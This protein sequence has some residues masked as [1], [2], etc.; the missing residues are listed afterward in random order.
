MHHWIAPFPIDSLSH[1]LYAPHRQCNVTTFFKIHVRMVPM[2]NKKQTNQ[3]EMQPKDAAD[4]L[5]MQVL[6]AEGL[7]VDDKYLT[8]MKIISTGLGEDVD[9][10]IVPGDGWRYHPQTNEIEFPVDMLLTASPEEII[11]FSAHEAG[12]RQVTRLNMR[13]G[14]FRN[15]YA[16]ESTRM[17]LNAVEDIRVDNWLTGV[18]PGLK[19]YL[20][21]AYE[22]LLPA[23]LAK[24]QYVERL[25]H[26]LAIQPDFSLHPY[27]LYPHLEYLLGARY[28]WKFGSL[29]PRT[30]SPEVMEALEK[31]RNDLDVIFRLYPPGKASEREKLQFAEETA[32]MITDKI[33]P[34][35]MYLVETAILRMLDAIQ[36]GK[37]EPKGRKCIPGESSAKE[38]K[39]EAKRVIEY[40]AKEV[41][42]KLSAKTQKRASRRAETYREGRA[43]EKETPTEE[44]KGE[45]EKAEEKK[46][47]L[48]PTETLRD[49]IKKERMISRDQA[50]QTGE[51]ER[52]YLLISNVIQMLSGIL[53]NHFAKNRRPGFTGYFRSGQKPDLR[54][55]M[56]LSRKLT[57]GI[58]VQEKDLKVFLKRKLPSQRDHKIV[59]ALDESG[60]MTEPKRTSALAGVLVFMEALD[61][62]G[63]DFAV[64]GFADSTVVHK[65]LG[66]KLTSGDK[67]DLFEEVAMCIP[68]GSTA[69][70][71]AL[72][73]AT[74]ILKDQPQDALRWIIMVTDGEG[75]INTT[76]K[77]FAQLQDEA[78]AQKIE[79]LG[80]GLDKEVTE[81]KKRYQTA[82]QVENVEELPDILSKILEERLVHQEIYWENVL[83]DNGAGKIAAPI[84]AQPLPENVSEL[85]AA[86]YLHQKERIP[87]FNIRHLKR[88]SELLGFLLKRGCPEKESLFRS[89]RYAFTDTQ[90]N[91]QKVRELL[92]EK[93]SDIESIFPDF[94]HYDMY[95]VSTAKDGTVTAIPRD[96]GTLLD[97][98]MKG[99]SEPQLQKALSILRE[100][101]SSS[102]KAFACIP[103]LEAAYR[104]LS[105]D[106]IGDVILEEL[107]NKLADPSWS[108]RQTAAL[109]LGRI[110]LYLIKQGKEADPAILEERLKDEDPSVC[111]AAADSLSRIWY[112]SYRQG[113]LSTETLEEKMDDE[114]WSVRQAASRT[115]GLIY[116][117]LIKEGKEINVS[118]MED[119]LWDRNWFVRQAEAETM[120]IVYP[121]IIKG[122]IQIDPNNLEERLKDKNILVR[123]TAALSLGRIYPAM[124]KGGNDVDLNKLEERLEDDDWSVRQATAQALGRIWFH[125][126][127]QGKVPLNLL[128]KKLAHGNWSVRQAASQ[129][130]G[131]IYPLLIKGGSNIKL[132]KLEERLHDEDVD[133]S[134]C[135][136]AAIALGKIWPSSY[137][138]KKIT[139]GALEEKLKDD[140][141]FVHQAAALAIINLYPALVSED[142]GIDISKLQR[143][144]KDKDWSIRQA[145]AQVSI[146]ITSSFI[147]NNQD[148]LNDL[149]AAFHQKLGEPMK[150]TISGTHAD[151]V[152]MTDETLTIGDI[153]LEREAINEDIPE[154]I[155]TATGYHILESLIFGYLLKHS[156]LLLGPTS[157][158][159]SFL[160]KWLAHVLGFKHLAYAIN[161]F[162]SKFEL[163]GGIK[164]DNEGHFIWHEGIILKAAHEG[165]WLVLE[166]INLASSEVVEILNDFLITGKI[167]YSENGQQR[168]VTPHP[169]FRLFATGNPESYS[170]RQKLSE[171]FISR[172]KIFYQK[173]LSEEE[174]SQVLSSLFR[175]SASMAL[176]IARFHI[177]LQNQADSRVIGKAEK[178]PY[179]FTLRDIIRIGNRLGTTLKQDA[180]NEGFLKK[181]FIEFFCVYMGRVRDE[182]EREAMVSL[183]D[184]Y[185]GFRA[186]G[187]DLEAIIPAVSKDI[188]PL[189][190]SLKTTRG[191]EFIPQQEADITPTPTQKETLYLILKALINREPV[192]L[193]GNPASG[194]TTL[195]RYLARQK[196]TNLYFVNLSSDTGLEEL[197][198]G[199]I[200]DEQ[201][202]WHYRK[203][204]LFDAME[205]GSWL[206]ID[207]ANL[208]P[209]SEYLNTLLDFGYVVDERENVCHAHPNFR[210]F[211]AIN[212][213]S[214]HQ[215]RN[216]LS[217]AL[218]SRFAEVWIEELYDS[219]ELA[220]LIDAW[221]NAHETPLGFREHKKGRPKV[222]SK[223]VDP[224]KK[225][226]KELLKEDGPITHKRYTYFNT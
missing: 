153:V 145:A 14:V 74:N 131:Q 144:L 225:T 56:E 77:S 67:R 203:G 222:H 92:L 98:L 158:G 89:I 43:E 171:I 52:V 93:L 12:H 182:A 116:P 9:L 95:P 37:V 63:V 46:D 164:P 28:Y 152:Q 36:E 197:L 211:L 109:A 44:G 123:Q 106:L 192:L 223:K 185:F 151:Q 140:N 165:L 40:S 25:R 65:P 54:K 127:Q 48:Q 125:S 118:R 166:E 24:S 210:L 87:T 71:D 62:I 57:Q 42:D 58:P 193:V 191:G 159:K 113:K 216:L 136:A 212:P 190:K 41:A 175:I 179:T 55:A 176:Q 51:Y 78:L 23:D 59:L 105:D 126:Y 154:C 102:D 214:V 142:S 69:D 33:L 172:F 163:I 53:E 146:K 100:L 173:E 83:S 47:A 15:F 90:E 181:L 114:S 189:L 143:R 11:G 16:R 180:A 194:K 84:E 178:D 183:L 73:L 26:E 5:Y 187:M 88:A 195:I 161:P 134:V 133:R 75:N 80:V 177:S 139:L 150:S 21:I 31:T 157:T 174:L 49:L 226:E 19:H 101:V 221:S 86:I 27:L 188:R 107:E 147:L 196:E 199:Y 129:A 104:L 137:S 218:K 130:L 20:D 201:G 168:E 209:L 10:K 1:F 66:G 215:S 61:H 121:G 4:L 207:E 167:S 219:G 76:G 99:A 72:Q 29:P 13:K 198:G 38:L 141:W 217:P 2:G 184:A 34:E 119:K 220:G 81:V 30:M 79:V 160:I 162:T 111:R 103:G 50:E 169:D 204:L 202:S 156:V 115:L 128:E 8:L 108:V 208:S 6:E 112:H 148:A 60:S 200:Q 186:S 149:L 124:M 206:L 7:V 85:L 205:E 68:A 18:F 213:P 138:M 155:M 120:G 96:V 35:Y 64:I 82:I 97:I 17:L 224:D 132:K 22:E 70:A 39:A 94:S 32:R 110:Y 170:Q 45:E 117:S 135:R 122:G 3:E 91:P